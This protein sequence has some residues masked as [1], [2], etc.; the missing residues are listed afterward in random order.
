MILRV[1]NQVSTNFQTIKTSVEAKVSK[2]SYVS[3]VSGTKNGGFIYYFQ[4]S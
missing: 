1:L 4:N 2:F 3:S